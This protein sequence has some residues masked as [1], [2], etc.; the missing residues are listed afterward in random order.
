MNEEGG[1]GPGTWALHPNPDIPRTPGG[2]IKT[3]Y[4]I[5][6]A[7]MPHTAIHA[8]AFLIPTTPASQPDP[9]CAWMP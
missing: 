7:S 8:R 6:T 2:H 3:V 5:K 4:C 1:P 9:G